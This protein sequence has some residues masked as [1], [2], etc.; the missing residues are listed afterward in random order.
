MRSGRTAPER[1]LT[2][3]LM[4]DIVGSTEHAAELGDGGWRELLGAPPRLV[5][6]ALRRHGGREIDTAGDG[7]F[8]T[9]DAPAAAVDCALEIVGDVGELGIEIRAGVHV[10]EVEQMGGK[11]T[12]G[13]TVVIASRIM[14]AAGRRARCSSPRRCAT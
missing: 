2:T 4:T 9:F 14:A 13:I 6:A 10:G 7:F 3:V 5:R 1:F 11:V 12:G 8:A